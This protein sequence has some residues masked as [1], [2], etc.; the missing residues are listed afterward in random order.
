MLRRNFITLYISWNNILI[1]I[2]RSLHAM[3]STERRF[4]PKLKAYNAPVVNGSRTRK[5]IPF[6][7]LIILK[8]KK[9][10]QRI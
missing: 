8:V 5:F 3:K 6:S 9:L 2:S 4:S 1:F 10:N 7:T